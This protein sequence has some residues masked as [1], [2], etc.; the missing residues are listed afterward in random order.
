MG[1]L[2]LL[3]KSILGGYL[4]KLIYLKCGSNSKVRE[5]IIG[6]FCWVCMYGY[7][8]HCKTTTAYFATIFMTSC[9]CPAAETLQST[10]LALRPAPVARV[11]LHG[12]HQQPQ[13]WPYGGKPHLRAD[14]L[15]SQPWGT[16]KVGRRSNRV[17][18]DRCH[19]DPAKTGG[20]DPPLGPACRSLFP[21]SRRPVDQLG[22][23]NESK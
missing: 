22:K 6:V 3:I 13:L 5:L 20:L 12:G 19:H 14:S 2:L 7:K 23:R 11:F 18:L 15:G 1:T 21:H 9:S 17:P 8:R 10:P 16:G 4:M